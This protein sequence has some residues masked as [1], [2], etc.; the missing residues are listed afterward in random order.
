MRTTDTKYGSDFRPDEVPLD[1][2]DLFLSQMP[3]RAVERFSD[4]AAE[5]VERYE[6]KVR[7]N[8]N[9]LKHFVAD[10]KAGFLDAVYVPAI[11]EAR[12]SRDPA[13]EPKRI[14]L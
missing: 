6:V 2:F 9:R 12:G 14:Y 4:A 5:A 13:V 10:R 1:G 3:T 8:I 11:A 7:T